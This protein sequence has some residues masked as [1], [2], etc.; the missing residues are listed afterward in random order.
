MIGPDVSAVLAGARAGRDQWIHGPDVVDLEPVI[1]G[2]ILGLAEI[3]EIRPLFAKGCRLRLP[4]GAGLTVA[5]GDLVPAPGCEPDRWR[6]VDGELR[7]E[8]GPE[9]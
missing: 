4:N 7:P 6:L 9:E 8:G 3:R 2:L 1:S 5:S